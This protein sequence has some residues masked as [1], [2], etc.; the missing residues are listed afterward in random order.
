[1]RRPIVEV[2]C[3]RADRTLRMM[4]HRAMVSY[5]SRG[6][7]RMGGADYTPRWDWMEARLCIDIDSAGADEVD[8]RIRR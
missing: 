7:E 6:S 2:F 8:E 1:M 4:G 3:Q 5:P